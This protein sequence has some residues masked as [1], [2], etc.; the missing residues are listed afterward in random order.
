MKEPKL[1]DYW[2][3]QLELPRGYRYRPVS[4]LCY[5]ASSYPGIVWEYYGIQRINSID[6]EIDWGRSR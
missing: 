2:Y 3:S 1:G 5:L 6:W 4:T